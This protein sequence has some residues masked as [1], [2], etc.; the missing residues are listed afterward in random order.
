MWN[1]SME[2][3][4]GVKATSRAVIPTDIVDY[5]EFCE[6]TE[7]LELTKLLKGCDLTDAVRA[8]FKK[9]LDKTDCDETCRL[10]EQVIETLDVKVVHRYAQ[11][12]TAA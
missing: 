7:T 5:K 9:L 10:L 8:E 2:I 1:Y 11:S 6:H 4:V 12:L 3:D